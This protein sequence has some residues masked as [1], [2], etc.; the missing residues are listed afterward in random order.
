M[1]DARGWLAGYL[2]SRSALDGVELVSG[3]GRDGVPERCRTVRMDVGFP[4]SY[5]SLFAV[6][7]H[8]VCRLSASVMLDQDA[9]HDQRAFGLGTGGSFIDHHLSRAGSLFLSSR[10]CRA[11]LCVLAAKEAA[12][13][14]F[15]IPP[16]SEQ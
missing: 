12:R 13:F 6:G 2:G 9:N 8:A 10:T 3:V 7:G 15:I 11:R 16:S 5:S 14:A 4:P 1:A